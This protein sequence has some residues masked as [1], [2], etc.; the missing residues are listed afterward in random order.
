[1]TLPPSSHEPGKA[2]PPQILPWLQTIHSLIE[3]SVHAQLGGNDHVPVIITISTEE[4]LTHS[5]RPSW[6]LKRAN[7]DQYGRDTDTLTSTVIEAN[8]LNKKKQ[9]KNHS[10]WPSC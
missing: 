1:M 5:M 10:P 8:D 9:T 6:S 2:S 3:R 7:W 4:C